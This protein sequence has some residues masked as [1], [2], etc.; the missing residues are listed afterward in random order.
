MASWIATL[1]QRTQPRKKE[2][3]EIKEHTKE[4]VE[5]EVDD[6]CSCAPDFKVKNN[7]ALIR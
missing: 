5:K 6:V 2:N 1:E 4:G 3:K 7:I